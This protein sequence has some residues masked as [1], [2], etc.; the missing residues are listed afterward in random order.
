VRCVL[1]VTLTVCPLVVASSFRRVTSH[2]HRLD[3]WSSA[4][5]TT[6]PVQLEPPTMR[7]RSVSEPRLDVMDR[8][9]SE[10]RRTDRVAPPIEVRDS[11]SD[12]GD[13]AFVFFRGP[14]SGIQVTRADVRSLE[15]G[16]EARDALFDALARYIWL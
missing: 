11:L 1:W 2:R 6:V 3:F 13:F 16:Q 15:A 9:A 7:T 5:R 10:V 14:F 8:S 4:L 12:D